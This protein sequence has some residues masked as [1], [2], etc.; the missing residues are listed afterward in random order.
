VQVEDQRIGRQLVSLMFSNLLVP[1]QSTDERVKRILKLASSSV[2]ATR[3][4][5]L[6]SK[7][8]LEFADAVELMQSLLVH[9]ENTHSGDV[10]CMLHASAVQ[11]S[12]RKE[13][14]MC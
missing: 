10:W 5:F 14:C 2:M 4:F 7:H 13:M 12:T 8:V 6:Y 3:N 11:C 1:K 9:L